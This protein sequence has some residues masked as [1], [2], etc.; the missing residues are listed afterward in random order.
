MESAVDVLSKPYTFHFVRHGATEPNE[1]GLRCGGDLDVALTDGGREQAR[2]VAHRI[3]AMQIEV[4]MIVCST[5][6]RARETATIIGGIL[7]VHRFAFE[8]LLNERMLGRWNLLPVSETEEL[9]AGNVPPPD[10]E[11]EK[12]FVKRVH[13]MLE[14]L[15]QYLPFAPLVVSSKGV[16]RVLNAMTG[17]GNRLTV[18]NGE[19]VHFKI[20]RPALKNLLTRIEI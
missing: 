2:A 16:A 10:G 17:D 12:A 7:G 13:V 15:S 1:R 11:S 3:R 8:P 19:I 4:G 18:P 5:L 6:V 14:Q 9:L 20:E